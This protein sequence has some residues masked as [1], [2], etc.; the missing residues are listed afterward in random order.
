MHACGWE[1]KGKPPKA[2]LPWGLSHPQIWSWKALIYDTLDLPGGMN[3]ADA[4][5][6]NSVTWTPPWQPN[7]GPQ[8]VTDLEELYLS[9]PPKGSLE[10]IHLR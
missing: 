8:M 2:E 1:L 3:E 4:W 10:Y 9:Y 5:N 6:R 7:T